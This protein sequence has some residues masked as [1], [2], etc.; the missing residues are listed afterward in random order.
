MYSFDE[1]NHERYMEIF[2]DQDV[3][4][5][6]FIRLK[7]Y[8]VVVVSRVLGR[9]CVGFGVEFMVL[10]G[11][12]WRFSGGGAVELDIRQWQEEQRCARLPTADKDSVLHRR[13]ANY[14]N[15]EKSTRCR[16]MRA[17]YPA[18]VESWIVWRPRMTE[19]GV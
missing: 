13:I 8:C 7:L 11:Q 3:F 2:F 6:R 16:L 5:A 15:K 1:S 17:A 12:E 9:F 10:L 18:D 14:C 19:M 4:Y